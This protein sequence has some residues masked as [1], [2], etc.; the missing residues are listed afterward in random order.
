VGQETGKKKMKEYK[1]TEELRVDG[2]AL[3]KGC[4]ACAFNTGWWTNLDGTPRNLD[5]KTPDGFQPIAWPLI[6]IISEIIEGA[7]GIRKGLIEL[8]PEN[9]TVG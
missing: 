5:P 1:T 8:D 4:H 3:A 2:E 7:E 9:E 6:L